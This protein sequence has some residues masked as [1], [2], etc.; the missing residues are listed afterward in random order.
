VAVAGGGFVVV[1]HA[2][3]RE[4]EACGARTPVARGRGG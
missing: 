4:D 3:A 1:T 2:R